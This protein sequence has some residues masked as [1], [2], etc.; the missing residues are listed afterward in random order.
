MEDPTVEI[1]CIPPRFNM[2]YRVTHRW[3]R[4]IIGSFLVA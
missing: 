2:W 3:Y 1:N 4:S